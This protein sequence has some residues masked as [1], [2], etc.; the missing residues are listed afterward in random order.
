MYVHMCVHMQMYAYIAYVDIYHIHIH[1][2]RKTSQ[3]R[4]TL[5]PA[6]LDPVFGI[7]RVLGEEKL[8]IQVAGRVFALR[9][10]RR[11]DRLDHLRIHPAGG[12]G[13]AARD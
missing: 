8:P 6:D 5:E 7:Q 2:H 3:A 13:N 9:V 4:Q 10:L 12:G 1:I 11:F